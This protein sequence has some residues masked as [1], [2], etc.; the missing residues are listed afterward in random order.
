MAD[1]IIYAAA[2]SLGATLVTG[3]A[4]FADLPGVEFIDGDDSEA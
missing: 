2:Q 4:H 3:D 1:A